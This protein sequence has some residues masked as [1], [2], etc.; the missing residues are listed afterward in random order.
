VLEGGTASLVVAVRRADGEPAVLK[1]AVPG[2]G[3][4]DQLKLLELADGRG[5]VRVLESAP[6]RDA[7]VLEHLGGPLSGRA[8]DQVPTPE[9]QIGTLCD[10]LQ[11]AWQLPVDDYRDQDWDKAGQLASLIIDLW[12]R[13]DRPCPY[14]V[15]DHALRAAHRL[16][17]AARDRWVVVHGDPHPG[18][19]LRTDHDR[20][21]AAGGYVFVDPDG[22]FADPC[23]DLG[24]VLRDWSDV[25]TPATA[26]ATID[27]YCA[28]AARRTGLPEEPIR[29]WAYLERVS[30]GLFLIS[31][32]QPEDGRRFLDR[33][34]WL[35]DG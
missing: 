15:V 23:Y 8:G 13:L 12:V 27:R 20:L 28:L 33:A 4:D 31:L 2:T 17:N 24:V 16:A 9:E 18:N 19:A 21:G 1:I 25:L 11:V 7:A 14:A 10:L 22:F 26:A 30:S 35:L 5:Y 6:E 34:G 29:D 32:G 3:F